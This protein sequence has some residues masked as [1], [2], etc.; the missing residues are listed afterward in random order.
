M[1]RTATTVVLTPRQVSALASP[2]RLEIAEAFGALGRAS[3]RELAAHLGRSPGAVYHHL[4]ALEQAGIISVVA[5]RAGPRR[6]EA[7]YAAAAQR[8]AV[9]AGPS[10]AAD[11][12][13]ARTLKAVLRQ[14]ARDVDPALAMGREA[15][16][17]RFH[18]LQLAAALSPKDFTRVLALLGRIETIFRRANRTRSAPESVARWT[19][20]LTPI[21]R[22]GRR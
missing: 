4:R 3:A 16:L 21:R 11:A 1:T 10:R 20:L 7:V 15:L 9:A 22:G 19:T 2:A 17:G 18:G 12:A 8:L 6:P 14:A 5:H 13:M